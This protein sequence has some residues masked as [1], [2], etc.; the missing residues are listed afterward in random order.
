MHTVKR[1]CEETPLT[2]KTE[3]AIYKNRHAVPLC[4]L[5]Q[6]SPLRYWIWDGSILPFQLQ[7]PASKHTGRTP[8][9][10]GV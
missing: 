6:D 5:A 8:G 2:F 9:Q 7:I 3:N 10:T 4:A 1:S